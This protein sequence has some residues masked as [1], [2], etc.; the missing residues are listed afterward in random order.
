MSIYSFSYI[1]LL[2]NSISF[3]RYIQICVN[4]IHFMLHEIMHEIKFGLDYKIIKYSFFCEISTYNFIEFLKS[5][6]DI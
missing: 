3:N 5:I 4:I 6:L 2:K 1:Y